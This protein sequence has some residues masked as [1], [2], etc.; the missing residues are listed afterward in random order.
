MKIIQKP[1]I[2]PVTCSRCHCVFHPKIKDLHA[3]FC[4]TEK[5]RVMCPICWRMN[6]V[7]FVKESKDREREKHLT[8]ILDYLIKNRR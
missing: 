2:N 1:K 5:A 4:L 7:E 6:D 3:T 8:S